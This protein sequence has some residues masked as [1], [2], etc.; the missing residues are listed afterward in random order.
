[1][2]NK[3]WFLFPFTCTM[4][5]SVNS[6]LGPRERSGRPWPSEL[7]ASWRGL[8]V[9]P[10]P[11]GRVNRFHQILRGAISANTLEPTALGHIGYASVGLVSIMCFLQV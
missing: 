1:M 2:V 5:S 3:S 9:C 6:D 11:L 10:F 7:P 4:C 8:G